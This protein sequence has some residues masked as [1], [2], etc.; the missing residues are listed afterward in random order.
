MQ[1][2]SFLQYI[3]CVQNQL[4]TQYFDSIVESKPDTISFPVSHV[5]LNDST[6]VYFQ[7]A[8]LALHPFMCPKLA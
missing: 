4:E 1:A 2:L 6:Y 7:R 8:H 5:S 3:F